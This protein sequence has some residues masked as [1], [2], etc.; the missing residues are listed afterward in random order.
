MGNEGNGIQKETIKVCDEKV[1]IPM[2]GR[3]ESLNVSIASGIIMWEMMR[4]GSVCG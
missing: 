1:T 3:A 4:G 2:L